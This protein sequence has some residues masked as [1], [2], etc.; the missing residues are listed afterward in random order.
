MFC[1]HKVKY[2][3]KGDCHSC[4]S[5]ASCDLHQANLRTEKAYEPLSS[6][7]V[8]DISKESLKGR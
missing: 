2:V 1:Y 6:E 4:E 3:E 7:E 5:A 8:K